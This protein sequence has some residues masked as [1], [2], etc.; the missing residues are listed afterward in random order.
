LAH[1]EREG[2]EREVG[3]ELGQ[4][5]REPV[6]ERGRGFWAGLRE[7]VGLVFSFSFSFFF[8]TLPIQTK[9]FEFNCNLNSNLYT[10]HK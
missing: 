6:R 7:G 9:P 4:G 1:A 8:F 2:E 10:Q 3:E 5:K